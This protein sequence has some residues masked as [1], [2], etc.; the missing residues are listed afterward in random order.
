MLTLILSFFSNCPGVQAMGSHPM[1]TIKRNEGQKNIPLSIGGVVI[2]PGDHIVSC[3]EY[4]FRLFGTAVL[5]GIYQLNVSIVCHDD[6]I[7]G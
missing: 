7:G 3:L 4:C 5:Q 2:N 6:T 1:K